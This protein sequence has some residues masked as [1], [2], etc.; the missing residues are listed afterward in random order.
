MRAAVERDRLMLS[1]GPA[2]GPR[3]LLAHGA[4][5][6]MDSDFMT[7]LADG[8]GRAG[9]RVLRFEF[10]YM[11]QRRQTGKK[12]PPDRAPVLLA[13]FAETLAAVRQEAGDRPVFI[14]G[15]SMGG[16]MATLLATEQD[17][18]GVCVYGYPFHPPGKPEK[19][20]TEHLTQLT[21]PALICQGERDSFGHR[22]EVVGY[23]LPAQLQLHWLPDGDHSL[24]PRK[25]SGLTLDDNLADAIAATVAFIHRYSPS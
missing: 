12:R 17:A 7:A 13:S 22:D 6:G 2:N 19:L 8:L 9:I 11:A 14:G 21:C 25:A 20:R 16:R 18:A 4:G 1:N 15:K 5:A 10:P 24:K 23:Q 3:L